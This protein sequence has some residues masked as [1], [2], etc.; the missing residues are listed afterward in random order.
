M[1]AFKPKKPDFRGKCAICGKDKFL[2]GGKCLD[3]GKLTEIPAPVYLVD[4]SGR[5]VTKYNEIFKLLE[6]LRTVGI[7]HTFE[8]LYDG[9]QICYPNKENRVV[10]V[11]EHCG[12]YGFEY[13]LLEI[14]GLLTPR[15]RIKDDVLGY[16]HADEVF[17]RIKKHYAEEGV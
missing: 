12:S 5:I 16:L 14:Q 11:I 15:E 10:S 2:V 3:C 8:P 1:K 17:N 13:D 7:P 4:N 9:F 6:M